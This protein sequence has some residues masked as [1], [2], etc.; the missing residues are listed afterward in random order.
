MGERCDNLTSA[1]AGLSA[2]QCA[3]LGSGFDAASPAWVSVYRECSLDELAQI[4]REGLAPTPPELRPAEVRREMEILDRFRPARVIESGVS[5]LRAIYAAPTPEDTPRLPFRRDRIILE[6]TIDPAGSRVGDMN[7]ITG[8]I[9]F[10]GVER[11][12]LERFHGAF[13][14]YWDGILPLSV[15]LD[16]YERNGD[17][18]AGRWTVRDNAPVGLPRDFFAPEILVMTP[19]IDQRHI[20]IVRRQ[21]PAEA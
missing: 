15:F 16:S 18:Q 7:F 12:G 17:G 4:A 19:V 10:L 11:G 1:F 6:M 3:L 2:G 21:P 9:P 5:R 8:L 13:R 20:R 14:R